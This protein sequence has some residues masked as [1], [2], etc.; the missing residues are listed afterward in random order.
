MRPVVELYALGSRLRM[1][2]DDDD[3]QYYIR[4]PAAVRR[5]NERMKEVEWGG[6]NAAG[7]E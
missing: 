7:G 2:D 6:G 1:N 5:T 3:R 4:Y